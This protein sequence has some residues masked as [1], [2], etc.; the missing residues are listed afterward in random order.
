MLSIIKNKIFKNKS[1]DAMAEKVQLNS[2]NDEQYANLKSLLSSNEIDSKIH[3]LNSY[4]FYNKSKAFEK[5]TGEKYE[6]Q[7]KPINPFYKYA[8][9]ASA[10][11]IIGFTFVYFTR[12]VIPTTQTYVTADVKNVITLKDNS[13]VTLDKNSNLNYNN[14]REVTLQGRAYFNVSKDQKNPFVINTEKGKITVLGTKFTVWTSGENME[15]AV[16]EGKVKY[17]YDGRS[18]ILEGNQ[19]M[20][21]VE[22]DIVSSKISSNNTFSWQQNALIFRDTPIDVVLNDLSR[23]F[24]YSIKLGT[25][26]KNKSK[27]LLTSSYQNESLEQ[28]LSELKTL[29]NISIIR[30]EKEYVITA[31]NC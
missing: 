13:I 17:E 22:N 4:K 23:H 1:K 9:A 28:V 11:F 6:P 15:V 26:I 21:L 27:C 18:I 5:I 8:A 25:N 19:W 3:D 29:F 14:N 24:G 2:W 16:E 10:I 20:K 7:I 31:I 12:D 30:K